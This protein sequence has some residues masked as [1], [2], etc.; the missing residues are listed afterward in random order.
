MNILTKSTCLIV[1]ILTTLSLPE[2]SFARGVSK[3]AV[4]DLVTRTELPLSY[5][6]ACDRE[7]GEPYTT[8]VFSLRGNLSSLL[9]ESSIDTTDFFRGYDIKMKSMADIAAQKND[10]VEFRKN[11]EG[12]R[13]YALKV[14]GSINAARQK[15][16][17]KRKPATTSAGACPHSSDYY[18]ERFKVSGKTSD[19][20]CY[21]KAGLRELNTASGVKKGA[22]LTSN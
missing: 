9:E 19:L 15:N 14:N 4:Q 3:D 7:F 2:T 20:T 11:C 18:N 13:S 8:Q 21:Q 10:L 1:T 12:Q 17:S 16:N 22:A 6:I 5:M